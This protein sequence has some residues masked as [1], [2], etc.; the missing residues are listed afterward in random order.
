MP[1]SEKKVCFTLLGFGNL[2]KG[3]Y[4]VWS[5]KQKKILEQTGYNLVLKYILIKNTHFRR[6]FN[7]DQKL[8]TH[9]IEKILKDQ[10]ITI[11]IDAIGDI[12]PTFSIIKKLIARKIHIVS[13][14]R[15]LLATKMREISDLANANGIYFLTE[16]SLGG[17]IPVSEIL[18]RDFV[19]NTITELY[20]IASG[21]SNYILQEMTQKKISLNDVL[22][23]PEIPVMAESLSV[24]D[25]EGSDAAMKISI[26]AATAFG[27]DINYLHIFAEG[28]SDVTKEDVAWA[29]Y[30]GYEIKLLSIL[31]DHDDSIEIR[32]HP[33]FVHKNHP[34]IAVKGKNNAYF[35]KT[36]LLGEYL[37]YGEGVGTGPTS[38]LILR[39]LVELGHRIY[40]QSLKQQF[41]FNWKNK[42]IKSIDDIK[43]SYYIRFPC[44]DEP[45]VMSKVT[46]IIG[47]R[48]IN[49]S[50]AHA[51]VDKYSYPDLGLIHIFLDEAQEK[52]VKAAM[53]E[54]KNLDLVKGDVKIFRILEHE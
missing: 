32:V 38:S 47:N 39:G 15:V 41:H 2:G 8:F 13:A 22:K 28:I 19:A 1:V 10:S 3:F 25:Y 51:E 33:T 16:P 26:L 7:I 17:G 49:I 43:T 27:I 23:Q 21:V 11:A 18:Q 5:L 29:D 46:T 45:G 31:R 14:N 20:G 42:K 54:I 30:F 4:K 6:P 52:N 53:K 12:E 34:M 50:S 48:K 44:K 35:I 36:D 37:V 24:I 40:S 9:D